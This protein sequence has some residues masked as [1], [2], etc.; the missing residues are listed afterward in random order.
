MFC[1]VYFGKRT[2]P[3]KGERRARLKDLGFRLGGNTLGLVSD[4]KGELQLQLSPNR[5]LCRS[6][7]SRA[8]CRQ[9]TLGP[10]TVAE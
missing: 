2:L 9:K 4:T 1:F 3:K 5:S 6:V 7:L 10:Q 8:S